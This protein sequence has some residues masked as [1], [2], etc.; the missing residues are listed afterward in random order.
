MDMALWHGTWLS[1]GTTLNLH[2][3][4]SSG[5]YIMMVPSKINIAP[6]IFSVETAA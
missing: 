5:A 3:Y 2:V 4:A 1:T 6:H